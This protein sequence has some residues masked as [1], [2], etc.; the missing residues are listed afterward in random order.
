MDIFTGGGLTWPR[1]SPS[2]CGSASRRDRARVAPFGAAAVW[3]PTIFS[4][5]NKTR[6][7]VE[8]VS[9]VCFHEPRRSLASVM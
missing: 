1:V 8:A 7:T 2:D 9:A 6:E 4:F 5:G 3:A